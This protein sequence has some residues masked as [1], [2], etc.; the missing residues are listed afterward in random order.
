MDLFITC[1][2]YILNTAD[3]HSQVDVAHIERYKAARI[4]LDLVSVARIN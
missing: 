3:T 2:N 1:Y 4:N